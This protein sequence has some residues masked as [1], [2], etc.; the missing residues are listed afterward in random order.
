MRT[1]YRRTMLIAP[2]LN[3]YSSPSM[4][5]TTGWLKRRRSKAGTWTVALVAID[6]VKQT[7]VAYAVAA[8]IAFQDRYDIS[9]RVEW[10]YSMQHWKIVANTLSDLTKR[11][12][13][14]GH[15]GYSCGKAPS[16]GQRFSVCAGIDGKWLSR[17]GTAWNLCVDPE[18]AGTKREGDGEYSKR[19]TS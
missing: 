4:L 9:C 16:K 18:V 19:G 11:E 6:T 2:W 3:P 5:K 15:Y 12:N 13:R 10:D 14:F 7:D 8:L 17:I 1:I